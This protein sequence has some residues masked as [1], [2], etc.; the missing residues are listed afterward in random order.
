MR[1][2]A[3][4]GKAGRFVVATPVGQVLVWLVL[5]GVASVL[6]GLDDNWDLQNYHLY[7]PFAFLGGRAQLDLNAVGNQSTFFPL[8]DL[9][10]YLLAVRWLPRW[11]RLVCFL[12]GLPYGALGFLVL[13]L[14]LEMG[15]RPRLAGAWL[16]TGIGMTGTTAVVEIGTTFGDVPVA[17]LVVGG[18]WQALRGVR[19][20]CW[21]RGCAWAGIACGLAFALKLTAVVF[22]PALLTAI[23]V[24]GP[25]AWARLAGGAVF[26][27]AAGVSFAALYGAWGWHLWVQYGDPFYPFL[28]NV[29]HSQWADP[30]FA[31]A[32][33]FLPRSA[34]QALF[35]PFYWLH[36]RAG[37]ASETGVRDWHFALAYIA[38]I[39]ICLSRRLP[40]RPVTLL[41]V[42]VTTGFALWEALFSILR[43]ALPLEV[44]TG[45][46]ILAALSHAPRN[47]S[48]LL[49]FFKKEDSSFLSRV[50]VYLAASVLIFLLATS[51]WPG[52][53]RVRHTP[54]TI[55]DVAAPSVPEGAT[56]AMAGEP[57]GFV[58]PFLQG[59][60]LHFVGLGA[61]P[62]T[63]LAQEIAAR[64]AQAAPLRVVMLDG[65]AEAARQLASFNVKPDVA[66]CVHILTHR[67][68]WGAIMLCKT[69]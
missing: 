57:E 63:R 61:P 24:C 49:L 15:F 43:Y 40:D 9:P 6:L 69:L 27:M 34:M 3:F 45:A 42:F 50:F 19:E 17:A 5:G 64:I 23:L 59:G 55:F 1:F 65:N 36:G 7:D 51:G 11:P 25:G 12:A 4:A 56:I 53:G 22:I 68:D 46:T 52:W 66:S 28:N 21:R 2:D 8:I 48:F 58:I 62:H 38:I 47:K 60:N 33:K 10:Y 44:M 32:V 26:L 31:R 39:S 29:F 54:A 20:G 35:Y 41:L 37:V 67:R 16:A 13:R 18:V 14:S 30:S